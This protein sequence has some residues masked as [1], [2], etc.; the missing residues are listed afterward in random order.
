MYQVLVLVGKSLVLAF[1]KLRVGLRLSG[2]WS[3]FM[4]GSFV[5]WLVDEGSVWIARLSGKVCV[6]LETA[7]ARKVLGPPS[8]KL[9]L[10]E[11]WGV[12]QGLDFR[13]IREGA[14]GIVLASVSYLT[15]SVTP[16]GAVGAL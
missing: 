10:Q 16:G 14:P 3:V 8:E 6:K 12:D 9:L 13:S 1:I 7:G 11:S 15:R 4:N 5:S 2:S